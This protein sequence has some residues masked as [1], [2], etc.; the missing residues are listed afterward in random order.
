MITVLLD[1]FLPDIYNRYYIYL[2]TINFGAPLNFVRIIFAP[3]LLVQLLDY[4]I[5]KIENDVKMRIMV[6]MFN[7]AR[8]LMGWGNYDRFNFSVL[9]KIFLLSTRN[10]L[11]RLCYDHKET[12]ETK[13]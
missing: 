5:Y 11:N 8:K 1:Q 3:F 2:K 10:L 7:D 6:K 13:D 12:I 9:Q 4:V